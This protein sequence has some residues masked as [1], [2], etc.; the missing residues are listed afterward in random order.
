MSSQ[1]T[2]E[3]ALE[4]ESALGITTLLPASPPIERMTYA[5]DARSTGH[6]RVH[7]PA[8]PTA[9]PLARPAGAGAAADRGD[10]AARRQGRGPRGRASTTSRT[11][12]ATT[13]WSSSPP[14]AAGWPRCSRSTP[15]GRR[16]PSP[17]RVAALTYL[18][19]VTPDPAG[20]G[21]RYH[22][23]EGVGECF[24]CPALT[25]DGPCDIV[26][27]EGVPGGPLDAW[28][29]VDT[30]AEHLARLRAAARP[31]TSRPRRRGSPTPRWSTTG[32]CCTAGSRPSYAARSACCP[33]GAPVL[34]MA[35]VVVLNDPL[36]SQGSNNATKS[37]SFYLEAVTA[38]DGAFDAAW[39]RAH[40]RQLLARL[41]AVG[42]RVDQLLAAAGQPAPAAGR[43]RGRPAPRGRRAGRGRLRRRPAVQPV[44]VRR[45]RGRRVRGVRRSG[46]SSRGF[47]PRDLRR[48]LGQYATGVTVVTTT[49]ADRRARSG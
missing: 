30:P 17:Q 29:D 48:A 16:T 21:L 2:F 45:R 15:T 38:H 26:V 39:M 28:D 46:P 3:S 22:C 7:D 9:G 31:S 42:H 27:V 49:D 18:H 4:V 43:R 20:P 36:T 8:L 24:T 47:D 5:T 11:W 35:D 12:P 40:V 23:V 1:I 13:T 41:G 33:S 34:G 6:G 19:G 44:V 25:V 10:R 37:A 14:A 32:R